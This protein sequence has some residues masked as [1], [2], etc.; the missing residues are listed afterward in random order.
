MAGFLVAEEEPL[1]GLVVRMEEGDEWIIGRDPDACFQVIEDPMV[2]RKHVVLSL[3]PEGILIENLSGVNPTAVN[4]NPL[5]S[6]TLLR[7]GDTV[8]IGNVFFRYTE[9]DPA[10]KPP[11]EEIEA[12]EEATPTIYEAS[13]E[14]D[15]LAFTG[16][17]DARWMI[18]V[19]SG[20]NAGAEFG[21]HEESSYLIGKNPNVCDLIFQDL[22]V[23][24]EH[25]RIAVDADGQVTIEDLNSLN[26]VMVNGIEIEE[27]VVLSTQDLV[28]L[29]TTSFLV[30]DKEQTRET[31]V[32][33]AAAFDL[34]P[35][36]Q[37]QEVEAQEAEVKK[38]WK[39]LTIP[40]QHL[41]WATLFLLL[42]VAGV[43]GVFTLFK[44]KPIL[45]STIDEPQE[46][47]KTLKS[48]PEVEFSFSSSNGKLFLLGHVMTEVNHQE[49]IHMLG[50]LPFIGSI[51][52]NVIIDELVWENTNALLSKNLSWRGVSLTS[53]IPGR[54]VL[55]GYV[56]TLDQ[57]TELSDYM[58]VNFLYLDRLENQVVVED[59][60]G[61]QIQNLLLESDLVNVLFKLSNGEVILSGRVSE[62]QKSKLEG[63]VQELKKIRGVR[64]LKNFVVL[65]KASSK[66]V[67]LSSRYKVT[68]HSKVG[69]TS[70]YVVI[71]GKILSE[72]D[73]LDGMTIK[74]VEENVV[75]LEK[76]GIKYRINYNQQ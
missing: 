41:I 19:I 16:G 43:G 14:L 12:I 8:Q 60:L 5:S 34:A 71:N 42:L 28:A 56:Q 55:R 22:S 57:S 2:S 11:E 54:F 30:I 31:I 69:N 15:S 7:E 23:S 52:D 6:P 62:T 72:G 46:I 74:N 65:T 40:T 53:V 17:A 48:F 47:T 26:K 29:G 63:T 61:A 64:L 3:T 9:Q 37:E 45:I 66:I 70:Q 32:S 76:D 39:K 18:K 21:L 50:E 1:K 73:F 24:R 59:T 68:G 10:D 35:S 4:D 58:N 49:M 75:F 20:P 27:K 51:D 33:P 38:N 36:S 44:S 25:A 67:D 13:E